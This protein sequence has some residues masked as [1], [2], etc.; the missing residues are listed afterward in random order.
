MNFKSGWESSNIVSRSGDSNVGIPAASGH[1]WVA[2]VVFQ[3]V[4]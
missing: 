1:G 4:G 2:L 3:P